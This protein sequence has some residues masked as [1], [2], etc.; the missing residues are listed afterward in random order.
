MKICWT[1]DHTI[2]KS[3]GLKQNEDRMNFWVNYSLNYGKQWQWENKPRQLFLRVFWQHKKA[4][5][6]SQENRRKKCWY[7]PSSVCDEHV[8]SFHL[9]T[10][11]CQW[12]YWGF[13]HKA[14]SPWSPADIYHLKSCPKQQTITQ[15]RWLLPHLC[16]RVGVWTCLIRGRFVVERAMH[17]KSFTL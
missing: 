9:S 7:L 5:T 15:T 10:C 16:R 8:V 4:Q 17:S 14:S 3:T 6:Y 12:Q 2:K 1:C 11:S 13:A